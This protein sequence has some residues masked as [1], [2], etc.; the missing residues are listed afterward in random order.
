MAN[1]LF[2]IR[3]VDWDKVSAGLKMAFAEICKGTDTVL[4]D[5]AEAFVVDAVIGWLKSQIV[6]PM[7][8]GSFEQVQEFE[9]LKKRADEAGVIIPLGLWPIILQLGVSFLEKFLKRK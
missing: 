7:A 5:L 9:E 1:E 6:N 8:L 2:D 4:D 3:K